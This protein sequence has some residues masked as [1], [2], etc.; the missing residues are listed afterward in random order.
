MKKNTIIATAY[1]LVLSMAAVAAGDHGP[2]TVKVRLD[3]NDVT[4][5]LA[6]VKRVE[7]CVAKYSPDEVSRASGRQRGAPRS[8][9]ICSSSDISIASSPVFSLSLAS[10]SAR[11]IGSGNL[12]YPPALGNEVRQ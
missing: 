10:L 6:V 5:V 8:S 3:M 1:S 2:D 12:W 4:S 7:R 11:L 9:A